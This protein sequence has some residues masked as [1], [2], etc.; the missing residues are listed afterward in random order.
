MDILPLA[1][2]VAS[3]QAVFNGRYGD[4]TDLARR[5]AVSRQTLYRQATSVARALDAPPQRRFPRLRRRLR[6]VR[7]YLDLLRRRQRPPDAFTS[8]RL[9]QFAATAQA[10]GVSLPVARRLL[11]VFLRERAP[12]VASLGRFARRAG[13]QAGRLLEVLDDATRPLVRQAAA[14][15]IFVGRR[16]VRMVVEPGSLCWQAG[17]LSARRDGASWAEEFQKLPALE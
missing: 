11:A 8:D 9:A 6:R 3:A 7:R 15:E 1:D 12:S 4:V 13:E 10:E 14:D 17:R 2:R 5:R 16:P